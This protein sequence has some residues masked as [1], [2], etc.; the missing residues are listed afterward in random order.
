MA[1]KLCA[2]DCTVIKL[3][4]L[5]HIY[6]HYRYHFIAGI[7]ILTNLNLFIHS[8]LSDVITTFSTCPFNYIAFS[9][10]VHPVSA[11]SVPENNKTKQLKTLIEPFGFNLGATKTIAQTLKCCTSHRYCVSG[12]KRSAASTHKPQAA[13]PLEWEEEASQRLHKC[14]DWAG[15]RWSSC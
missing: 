12:I 15:P 8:F 14:G 13:A 11:A 4:A 5:F 10:S 2:L 9:V 3:W 7:K 1:F 6:T